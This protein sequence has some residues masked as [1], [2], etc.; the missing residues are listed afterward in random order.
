MSKKI[1]EHVKYILTILIISSL[2][3][4]LS[5][6]NHVQTLE[7]SIHTSL[8]YLTNQL[9]T[10]YTH[11]GYLIAKESLISS[12]V[13]KEINEYTTLISKTTNLQKKETQAQTLELL[14]TEL[15][16]K[17][18]KQKKTKNI[19]NILSYLQKSQER[20]KIEIAK[21]NANVK[22]YNI[23]IAKFPQKLILAKEKKVLFNLGGLKLF[24]NS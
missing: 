9:D 4:Y 24:T 19:Q 20:L 6:K 23:F 7:N 22:E 15:A 18:K 12:S 2:V 21:Y 1:K 10:R 5:T 17:I 14:L 16:P 8:T 13:P 11:L 3:F